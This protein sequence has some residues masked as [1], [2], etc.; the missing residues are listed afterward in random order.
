MSSLFTREFYEVAR[1]RLQPGGLFAQ[2]VHMYALDV[3]D[4]TM[5]VRTLQ[6]VFPHSALLWINPKNTILI[7]ATEPL[8]MDGASLER[9]RQ[10]AAALPAVRTDLQRYFQAS[11][12]RALVLSRFLL[13]DEDLKRL[14][15]S[16]GARHL[17]TDINLRLEFDAPRRLFG[18][19]D[20][21]QAPARAVLALAAESLPVTRHE[22]SVAPAG[23][24]LTAM[25]YQ[26]SLFSRYGQE[27][28]AAKGAKA[29]LA[30]APNDE[31]FLAQLLLLPESLDEAAFN[32]TSRKLVQA[33]SDEAGKVGSGL[34]QRKKAKRAAVI[35]Q[36][37]VNK[38]PESAVAWMNLSLAQRA[39]GRMEESE[40]ARKRALQLDP[41]AGI[42]RATVLALENQVSKGEKA[43]L[44]ATVKS[45]TGEEP[46]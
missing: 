22:S 7:G 12:A 4:Y 21:A 36:A 17:H 43:P 41:L 34:W 3:T 25:K 14:G 29:G 39:L 38:H 27:A 10:M 37:L 20:P 8:I 23:E 2:W 42:L 1:R 24:S 5:I 15:A 26:V 44:E 35:F 45:G 33:S 9:A 28:W 18:A 19:A 16:G 40:A 6:S 46:Q 31:F 13:A 11:S 32:E 30:L